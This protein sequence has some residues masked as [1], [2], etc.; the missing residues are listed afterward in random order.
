M[1]AAQRGPHAVRA[2]AL[3]RLANGDPVADV[4]RSARV[5]V[6]TVYRWRNE[7]REGSKSK[8]GEVRSVP[9]NV[10]L[11][12]RDA[13]IA[14]FRERTG[15]EPQTDELARYAAWQ[16]QWLEV[17][18]D[19]VR[20]VL[21]RIRAGKY[22]SSEFRNLLASLSPQVRLDPYAAKF[23]DAVSRLAVGADD[24]VDR[25]LADEEAVDIF[26]YRETG[27]PAQPGT[28][29][30][31]VE[32]V[33]S[34]VTDDQ[35]E[36]AWMR[37]IQ[38]N[39]AA[40]RRGSRRGAAPKT[41]QRAFLW[42]LMWLWRA[43][44]RPTLTSGEVALLAKVHG[45][46]LRT[47]PTKGE[48]V[49]QTGPVVAWGTLVA[50]VNLAMKGTGAALDCDVLTDLRPETRVIHHLVAEFGPNPARMVEGVRAIVQAA[51]V[52]EPRKP[53]GSV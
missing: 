15:I 5:S 7:F 8:P 3:L 40:I 26:D 39:G 42:T 48:H 52:L 4:A 21:R 27:G 23:L 46:A 47:E 10:A 31:F 20:Q 38:A 33:D 44:G 34:T 12:D 19:A 53:P 43:A 32:P 28:G 30:G 29:V 41:S 16:Y 18:G 14:V 24:D 45:V 13:A 6:A 49:G 25:L 1:D 51:P 9:L 17:V 50:E 2:N 11:L 22:R 35:R 36:A 37:T